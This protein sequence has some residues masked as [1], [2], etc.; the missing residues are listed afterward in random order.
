MKEQP[1][2]KNGFYPIRKVSELTGINPVT[3]RAWERRYGLIKP[4]RTP[5]GHRL[6]TDDHIHLIRQ[7]MDFIDQGI[8]IGQV[9]NRLSDN[10]ASLQAVD[11]PRAE[12]SDVWKTYRSRMLQ[13]IAEFDDNA[14]D[15]SYNEALSLY[16]IELVTRLLL[17]PMLH[18]LQ[19][20]RSSQPLAEVEN[21]FF[22]TYLRNKLG[23][24]FHHQSAQACGRRLLGACLPN[25]YSEVE[26]LLF[27]LKAMT[28]G[29]R[30][31]LLGPDL[32]LEYLPMTINRAHS[33]ALVLFGSLEPPVALLQ[34]HLPA[35]VQKVNQPVFIG[36]SITQTHQ[37]EILQAGAIPLA[38]DLAA[39]V[40][41]ID[42][43]LMMGH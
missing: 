6:Y 43:R 21:R 32:S 34:S 18:E 41:Q 15:G 27:S 11:S 5:K 25:E 24:R 13:A 31:V 30:P 40:V 10:G 4:E 12:E 23:A 9:K 36:G 16:P 37:A 7:I 3:L 19:Q 39:A 26:L 2:Y 33:E 29:Y 42:D 28:Q 1:S 14:L 17:Q 35:L 8:S 38:V 22:H 20:R